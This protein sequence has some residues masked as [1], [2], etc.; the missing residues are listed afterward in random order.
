MARSHDEKKLDVQFDK[1]RTACEG[2][3]TRHGAA[4]DFISEEI[5]RTYQIE[6]DA[7]PYREAASAIRALGLEVMPRWPGG[8]TDG[9]L[10]N[11]NGRPRVGLRTGMVDEHPPSEHI[12]IDDVI[13]A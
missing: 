4:I 3:A 10:I 7:P 1:M 2:A 12:S 11:S 5:Y 9:N 8:G 6:D 13:T